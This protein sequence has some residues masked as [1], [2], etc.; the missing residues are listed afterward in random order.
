MKDDAMEPTGVT[1]CNRWCCSDAIAATDQHSIDHH[2]D[3]DVFR[4]AAGRLS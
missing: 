1:F 3:L 4:D 2:P